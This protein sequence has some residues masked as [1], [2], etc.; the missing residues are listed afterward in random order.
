MKRFSIFVCEN[1]IPEFEYLVKK[2]QLDD[3]ELVSFPTFCDGGFTPNEIFDNPAFQRSSYSNAVL[4][5]GQTCPAPK[6]ASNGEGWFQIVE[7]PYC[8]SNLIGKRFCRFFAE[9][10][11]YVVSL[12]WL[13]K[14]D[15]HLK[16]QGFTQGTAREY[17]KSWCRKLLFLDSGIDGAAKDRLDKLSAYLEIPNQ[18]IPVNINSLRLLVKEKLYAWKLKH[19]FPSINK[20]SQVREI[21]EQ[22]ANNAAALHIISRIAMAGYKRDVISMLDEFWLLIF[23]ATRSRYWPDADPESDCPDRIKN[24]ELPD[25]QSFILDDETTTLYAPLKLGGNNYGVFEAGGFLFPQNISKYNELFNSVIKIAALAISNAQRYEELVAS[26]NQYEYISYHDDL[27]GLYNR[28]YYNKL[29]STL[30]LSYPGGVFVIDVDGLKNVN[31]THG[32]SAGDT[33]IQV[34]AS[35]LRKIFR[36]KDVVIRLGGDEFVVIIEDC[37]EQQA[38]TL[39]RRLQQNMS[40]VDTTL[41][42]VEL[43]M[44]IG[45]FVTESE[46]DSLEEMVHKADSKMYEHKRIKKEGLS[47]RGE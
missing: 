33:L 19:S 27:T 35:T 15:F 43:S 46:E 24:L 22:N 31:D 34:A 36:A 41:H 40:A 4:F 20:D 6:K 45:Y 3:I 11:Y 29:C 26:R 32:H 42:D 44:S 2:E 39:L 1:Y 18:T 37:D 23:G 25:G 16:R 9:E 7:S 5:C 8:Y 12:G 21:Q 30:S 38:E 28:A 17:Y 13:N 10:G 47:Y 14:W